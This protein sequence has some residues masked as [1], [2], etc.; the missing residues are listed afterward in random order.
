LINSTAERKG[1]EK[2]KGMGKERGGREGEGRGGKE[3]T[4]TDV[5]ALTK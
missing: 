4:E 2:G 5:C 3:K 1:G